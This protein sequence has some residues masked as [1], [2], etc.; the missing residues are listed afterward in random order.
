MREL[1]DIQARGTLL[2]TLVLV[3]MALLV[4]RLFQLQLVGQQ[5][6]IDRSRRNQVR[7]QEIPPHRG[8]LLD[9]NGRVLVDNRPSYTVYGVP[10]TL[11]RDSSIVLRLAD[12]CD[13]P[14]DRL[15]RRLH[16]AGR[17]SMKA[18]RLLSDISFDMRVVL[19]ENLRDYPGIKVQIEPKRYYPENL[20]PHTVGYLGEVSDQE[21]SAERFP[22]VEAGDLVGKK[23]VER[24]YDAQIRGLKGVEYIMVDALGRDKGPMPGMPTTPPLHGRDLELTL[25]YE[26]QT[27][28][29]SLMGDRQGVILIAQCRTGEILAS[30][31]KPDFHPRYFSGRMPPEVWERLN[32][33][34]TRPLFNRSVQGL[35]PPG[36]LFKIAVSGYALEHHLVEE[37][38]TVDCKGAFR[39]GR[40]VQ[41]CWKLE[42]HGPMNMRQA[43]I[44]SCDVWFYQL[45]LRMSPDDIRAAGLS[46]GLGVP[47]GIDIDGESRDLLPDTEWYDLNFGEK[48]WSLGVMLNLAI[49]QGEVLTTPIS[50]LRYACIVANGG[51]CITPHY[52]R[53]LLDRATGE[54]EDLVYERQQ[55]E[56]S[57]RTWAMVQSA[58]QGVVRAGGTAG[59]LRRDAYEAGGKTGTAENPHGKEHSLFMSWMPEPDPEIA[60]FVLVENAGHGSEIAAPIAF[61]LTDY[62]YE[63]KH[64]GTHVSRVYVPRPAA[65][66]T[67]GALASAGGGD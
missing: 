25:D 17:G 64:P 67:S 38:F 46:F 20:A 7:T 29:D 57:P 61:K 33:E 40:H 5:D 9:R 27:L 49:G 35:Y 2:V 44:H 60:V 37:N 41:R 3:G 8:L 1:S 26:L 10:H 50:L 11:L 22:G 59:Y 47:T 39:L 6:W 58:T 54:R 56:L 21:L 15:F 30:V 43:V 34:E 63:R 42:G 51:W 62:W 18:V 24:N 13:A 19:A 66:D 28:A 12:V 65:V 45:G 55:V 52:G 36:S 23:G 53:A 14:A 31:S 48:G 16:Q 32:N 4:L